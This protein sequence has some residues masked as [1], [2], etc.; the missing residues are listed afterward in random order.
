MWPIDDWQFWVVTAI[1]FGVLALFVRAQLTGKR[2]GCSG[3]ASSS[4]KQA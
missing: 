4:R 2:A 3:C 1:C